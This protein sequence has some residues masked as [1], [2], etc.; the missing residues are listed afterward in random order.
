[1]TG[2]RKFTK[3][4]FSSVAPDLTIRL[5]AAGSRIAGHFGGRNSTTG[6]Q[7]MN[8]RTQ[9]TI[10]TYAAADQ[11]TKYIIAQELA[12]IEAAG[13][14]DRYCDLCGDE[15]LTIEET[16]SALCYNCDPRDSCRA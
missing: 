6:A 5:I 10:A 4:E 14:V 15:L 11:L 2:T 8:A 3:R 7:T 9:Q 1:M 13:T 16:R 12:R